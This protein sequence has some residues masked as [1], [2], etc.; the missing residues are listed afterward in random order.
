MTVIAFIDGSE[1]TRLD[2]CCV[3]SRER[4]RTQCG[5]ARVE[6]FLD[7]FVGEDGAG[8]KVGCGVDVIVYV[9]VLKF[10]RA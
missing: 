10:G 4:E 8:G 2:P 1:M 6:P 7:L 9:L 3:A 5:V